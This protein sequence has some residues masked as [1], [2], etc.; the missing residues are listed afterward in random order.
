MGVKRPG[1]EVN[2]LPPCSTEGKNDWRHTCA[3][4]IRFRGVVMENF[5]FYPPDSV[6]VLDTEEVMF[7][8][9]DI[10]L[11]KVEFYT[12]DL[13]ISCFAVYNY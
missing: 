5:T 6:K 1:R 2:H 12:Y 3:S 11:Q 10:H 7:G 4:L 13:K 8:Q 9:E